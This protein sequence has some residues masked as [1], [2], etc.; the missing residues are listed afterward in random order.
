MERKVFWDFS[1]PFSIT[2]SVELILHSNKHFPQGENSSIFSNQMSVSKTKIHISH[3]MRGKTVSALHSNSLK[4]KA[5]LSSLGGANCLLRGER[6]QGSRGALCGAWG[7]GGFDC[8]SSFSL[9][10]NPFQSIYFFSTNF[11]FQEPGTFEGLNYNK[12]ILDR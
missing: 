3:A 11:Q 10:I 5:D 1:F 6:V 2:V 9:S 12:I 4:I 8:L 7:V